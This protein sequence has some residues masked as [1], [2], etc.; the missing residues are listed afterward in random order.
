MDSIQIDYDS[1]ADVYDVYVKADNDVPFF[2][3]EAA[4]VNGPVL[5]LTSGTGR[6]SI[7][8]V[9]SG[10]QLT[11]VDVSPGMLMVLARKLQ[12]RGLSAELECADICDLELGARFE[13]AVLPF[14]S[15][16]EIRGGPR[17]QQ[18]LSAVYDCL[19]PGGRFICTMHNPAVRGARVD[20]TLRLVGRFPSGDGSLVV[21]GFESGG[22]PVVQRI[23]FFEFYDKD[24]VLL[25]KKLLPMEFELIEKTRFEAMSSKA[26][27]SVHTLFGNYDRSPFDS[28]AS[29][30]MIWV[31]QKPDA[32]NAR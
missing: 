13:L 32:A 21:S 5:E 31:L 25:S 15:F 27:F 10:A 2:L 30:V 6:L 16:M 1:I 26:G 14:Q 3:H 28:V 20:G 9:E 22:H 18:A 12:E 7:P 17:Q 24:G 23:Q 29:P 11:C 4:R 19:R 8:L